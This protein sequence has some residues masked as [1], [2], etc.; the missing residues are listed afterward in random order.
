MIGDEEKKDVR[1]LSEEDREVTL[2][3]L[4]P[5]CAHL[6]VPRTTTYEQDLMPGVPYVEGKPLHSIMVEKLQ[7][8][9]EAGS[10]WYWTGQPARFRV[11]KEE[12]YLWKDMPAIY[13][14]ICN[15][16]LNGATIE[17]LTPLIEAARAI[18]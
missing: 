16:R 1:K 11:T 13:V 6:L 5:F 15:M 12:G 18:P 14:E 2:R 17:E 4:E 3:E 9:I 7:M 10:S 8:E